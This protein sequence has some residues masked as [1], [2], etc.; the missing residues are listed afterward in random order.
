MVWI[1]ISGGA[2]HRTRCSILRQETLNGA[3]VKWSL[4]VSL[5]LTPRWC[6]LIVY[7]QETINGHVAGEHELRQ[8]DKD[9]M[10]SSFVVS[11]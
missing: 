7:C 4:I 6:E 10:T 1:Y 5:S 8:Y 2:A 9:L 11:V 3:V